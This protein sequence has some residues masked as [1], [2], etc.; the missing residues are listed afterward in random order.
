[1]VHINVIDFYTNRYYIFLEVILIGITSFHL[2]VFGGLESESERQLG[3]ALA[4]APQA[5]PQEAHYVGLGHLHRPQQVHH[6]PQICR[7]S[8]SPPH[9]AFPKR[10]SK[11]RWL[12]SMFIRPDIW[13]LLRPG[14]TGEG[15]GFE[16]KI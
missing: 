7:Y 1:L 9:L 8:G 12:L 16:D 3:G 13:R 5:L 6:A 11:K 14:R 15:V 10:T 2:F 4:V